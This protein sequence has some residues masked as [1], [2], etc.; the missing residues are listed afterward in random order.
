MDKIIFGQF[1]TERNIFKLK[2]F[3]KWFHNI[4]L[5][6]RQVVLEPFAGSN[7]I[8]SLL[9]EC[10]FNFKAISYDIAPNKKEVKKRDTIND[11]PVEDNCDVIITNPPYLAKNSATRKNLSEI[12]FKGHNDLYE[13]ALEVCLQNC[14]YIAAIIPVTFINTKKFK[15]RLD[16]VVVLNYNNIFKDTQTPVCLA[17]FSPQIKKEDSFLVYY[18]DFYVGK[19]YEYKK[20]EE[21][22]LSVDPINICQKSMKIQFNHNEGSICLFAVDNNKEDTIYFTHTDSL[23]YDLINKPSSRAKSRIK[24][25][26]LINDQ[27]I[28]FKEAD[29][30]YEANLIIQEYRIKTQDL[31]LSPFKGIRKDGKYRRRLDFRCAKKI[32][33]KTIN[34][35]EKKGLIEFSSSIPY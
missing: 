14:E 16:S 30:I 5:M 10:E 15:D 33:A 3:E 25:D 4:P 6:K 35:L 27:H 22:V 31:F 11:F 29:F 32:I 12:N 28:E 13:L 7:N 8:I 20:L 1:F 17:L 9:K 26:F 23:N 21:D 2:A 19:F 34:N 24:I 18:N